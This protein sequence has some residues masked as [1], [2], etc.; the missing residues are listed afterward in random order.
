[1]LCG[2]TVLQRLHSQ[3]HFLSDVIG[4][5]AA[6]LLWSYVCL[7]PKLIGSLFDKMEPSN[8][9]TEEP[10]LFPINEADA[11]IPTEKRIEPPRRIAA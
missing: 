3:S 7:S 8:V 2:L 1:M 4:G 9:S 6:G 10:Q 11:A 5:A